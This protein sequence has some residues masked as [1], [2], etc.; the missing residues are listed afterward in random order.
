[1]CGAWRL[2]HAVFQKMLE[3]PSSTR[4]SASPRTRPGGARSTTRPPL[5]QGRLGAGVELA[6]DRRRRPARR[7]PRRAGRP[8]RPSRS[9]TA[10]RRARRRG[11]SEPGAASRASG[12]LTRPRAVPLPTGT[13]RGGSVPRATTR[14]RCVDEPP[15][16]ARRSSGAAPKC[17]TSR[18]AARVSAVVKTRRSSRAS[19][20][21]SAQKRR[22]SCGRHVA[23]RV[24]ERVEDADERRALPREVVEVEQEEAAHAR[25]AQGRLDLLLVEERLQLAGRVKEVRG[26][27]LHAAGLQEVREDVEVLR[28]QVARVLRALGEVRERAPLA[29]LVADDRHAARG[30]V[31]A[32]VGARLRRPR[33]DAR[34]QALA[35]RLDARVRA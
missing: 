18:S 17:A 12:T 5:A 28:L 30:D 19:G 4:P 7:R 23:L 31:L 24:P 15:R 33:V 1:M 21:V 26:L 8:T 16:R 29:D 6:H 14:L 34:A 2:V 25:R 11:G 32:V 35:P 13:S 9:R 10:C 20:T 22:N 27:V 3:K